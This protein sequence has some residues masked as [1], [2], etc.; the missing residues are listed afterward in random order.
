[1]FFENIITMPRLRLI[2]LIELLKKIQIQ[3]TAREITDETLLQSRLAPDMLPLIRQIQIVTDNAK[4]TA[5]RLSAKEIIPFEDTE[6]TLDALIIRIQKTIDIL[7]TFTETDFQNAATIE[8]RLPWFP[9]K[10]MLGGQC[11]FAYALPNFFFH[12]VTTYSILRNQ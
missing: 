7:D 11:L 2:A 12:L 9:D 4:N 5:F 6:T 1:M 10:Y 8:I 3:S